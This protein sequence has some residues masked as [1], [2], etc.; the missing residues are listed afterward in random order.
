[1]DILI[2]VGIVSGLITAVSPC[3]LPVLPAIL[4]TS[5]PTSPTPSPRRPYV[6]VAGLVTSF[7]VF[8]LLGAALIDAL[9][10]PDD[11]LRWTGIV[12]LAVVGLGLLIRPLGD[13]I[14]RPFERVRLPERWREGGAFGVGAA[15]GLVFVPCAGPILAA[16]T[17]QAATGGLGWRLVALTA[18]FSLGL[19]V[20]LVLFALAGRAIGTRIKAVRSRLGV[21]RAVSGGILVLTALVIAT[22]VA[23]PLQRFVPGYQTSIE[24]NAAV[25]RELANLT[26]QGASSFDECAAD[27]GVLQ[28]CGLA[29]DLP[30]I[31]AWLNTPDG[32]PLD[33]DGLRGSV[34]LIDFWTYSCINCQ[35]T[36]PYLTAW[37]ERYA[38]DGLVIIGV[39]SPEFAFE[40]VESN[41]AA[42][43]ERFG[44]EYPIA[45]DNDFTTWLEWDQRYWPAHYLVDKN[46]VVRQVHYGEGHYEETEALIQ[47]LLGAQARDP[48]TAEPDGGTFGRSPETYLGSKRAAGYFNADGAFGEPFEFAIED[49]PTRDLPTLGGTW[50]I[51]EEYILAGDDAVLSYSF[52][53]SD[54]HLVLGGEGTIRVTLSGEPGWEN[55]VE[56]GG[57]PML[58][59]L[60]T[61]ATAED[62]MT[63]EFTPGLK[64][65]AFTFG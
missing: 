23:E 49:N 65:Y 1:M 24:S 43:A 54:V 61:G 5:T 32:G 47:E 22:N 36:F 40:K 16:I 15:L 6:V 64:A 44:I 12:V 29:R 11:F 62:L 39:H 42:A 27:P 30:G 26:G 45:L 10:L 55:V 2:V 50:T 20:P 35:R 63:I 57:V 14:S 53:A 31:E 52:L 38:D 41:V 4:A 21:L 19:A 51:T 9:R 8:T 34:V 3:V 17:V 48:F 59:T 33:L 60:Y 46:G 7:A 13:L 18:A 25:Q 58:Y 37:H 56:V 28:N